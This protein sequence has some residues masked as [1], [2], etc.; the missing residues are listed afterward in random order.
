MYSGTEMQ[1]QSLLGSAAAAAAA[2]SSSTFAACSADVPTMSR[3]GVAQFLH[4]TTA[5]AVREQGQTQLT[6]TGPARV[7]A[8]PA[9]ACCGSTPHVRR[10]RTAGAHTRAADSTQRTSEATA[11]VCCPPISRLLSSSAAR[12][13]LSAASACFAAAGSLVRAARPLHLHAASF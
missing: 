4:R 8:A 2:R 3:R 6:G 1:L 5:A 13:W 11:P 9:L 7:A 10:C 12:G